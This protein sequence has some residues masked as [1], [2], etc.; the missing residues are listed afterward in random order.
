MNAGNGSC[1]FKKCGIELLEYRQISTISFSLL[2]YIFY[3]RIFLC[4]S[5]FQCCSLHQYSHDSYYNPLFKSSLFL[6]A[7]YEEDLKLLERKVEEYNLQGV[8]GPVLSII[9]KIMKVSP[10]CKLKETQ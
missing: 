9:R 5:G 7:I 8:A 2:S 3:F 1:R 4:S 6:G 10:L